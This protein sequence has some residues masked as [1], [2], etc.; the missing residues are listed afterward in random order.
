MVLI[1]WQFWGIMVR[2]FVECPSSWD[3]SAVYLMV[4][5]GSRFLRERP[6]MKSAIFIQHTKASLCQ[7]DLPLLLRPL[8][9]QLRK[10]VPC[11]SIVKWLLTLPCPSC[12]L[13]K[14]V[15][16]GA[17]IWGVE[18]FIYLLEFFC[19]LDLPCLHSFIQSMSVWTRRYL[20]YA[21]S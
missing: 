10:S 15:I 11:F 13:W 4:R 6:Q 5:L 12:I 1:I 20:V 14:E 16:C 9:S 18:S 21:L 19:T 8:T 2:D 7:H 3:F 17:C